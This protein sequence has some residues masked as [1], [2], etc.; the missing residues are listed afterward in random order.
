MIVGIYDYYE[1]QGLIPNAERN[2]D[3]IRTL[4]DMGYANTI[5]KS[6]SAQTNAI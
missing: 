3:A 5:M 2:T 4:T 1:S 6:A